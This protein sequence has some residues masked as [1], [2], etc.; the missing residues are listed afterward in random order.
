MVTYD[1]QWPGAGFDVTRHRVDRD[2]PTVPP[3]ASCRDHDPAA[4]ELEGPPTERMLSVPYAQVGGFSPV[5][6]PRRHF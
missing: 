1:F 5:P 3:P 4:E 6:A 2:A